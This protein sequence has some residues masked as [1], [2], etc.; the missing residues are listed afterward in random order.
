[1][2]L[3]LHNAFVTLSA[4]CDF[5]INVIACYR[6]RATALNLGKPLALHFVVRT[7]SAVKNTGR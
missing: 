7:N 5:V 2:W 1:M 4:K 3:V 6:S